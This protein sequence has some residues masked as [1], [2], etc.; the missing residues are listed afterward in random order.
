MADPHG[1]YQADHG[2]DGDHGHGGGHP[3][4]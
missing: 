4:R 3:H 2:H 1:H